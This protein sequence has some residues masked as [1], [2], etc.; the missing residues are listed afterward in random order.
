[1]AAAVIS[2]PSSHHDHEWAGGRGFTTGPNPTGYTITSLGVDMDAQKRDDQ[3]GSNYPPYER[4]PDYRGLARPSV[5]PGQIPGAGRHR[6]F[7]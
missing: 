1:M 7:A 5:A 3:P 4:I 6:R 2:S